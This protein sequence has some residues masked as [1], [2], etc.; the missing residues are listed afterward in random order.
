M[1]CHIK[2]ASKIFF[3]SNINA[4]NK[5]KRTYSIQLTSLCHTVEGV[6]IV[7]WDNLALTPQRYIIFKIGFLATPS[8]NSTKSKVTTFVHF[9][10]YWVSTWNKLWS[11]SRE[12]MLW[13]KCSIIFILQSMTM[14]DSKLTNKNLFLKNIF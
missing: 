7:P 8:H 2:K 1:G 10:Q 9:Y 13:Q 12:N 4:I 5:T 14:T 11:Y 3:F 6:P